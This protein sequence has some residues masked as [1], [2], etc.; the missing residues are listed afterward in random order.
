MKGGLLS[1]SCL[2]VS[3]ICVKGSD[4]EGCSRF[5]RSTCDRTGVATPNIRELK[6]FP[7]QLSE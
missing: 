3:I 5:N 7:S 4:R 6:K 2:E 1:S